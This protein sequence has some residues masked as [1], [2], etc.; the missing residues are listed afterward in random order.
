MSK[1]GLFIPPAYDRNVP[2]LGTPALVGFLKARGIHAEQHDLNLR[3]FAHL[4]RKRINRLFSEEYR[5]KKI[6]EKVYYR[7]I[8]QYEKLRKPF[9]YEFENNPGS[10]FAFAEKILSS[11]ILFRYLAD[12]EENLFVPFFAA[13]V[14]PLVQESRYDMVGFSLTAPSQ[15][16]AGFTFGYLLKKAAP[17]IKIVIG[18]QWVSFYREAL[19]KRK[20]FLELFDFMITF[21]GETPLYKLI[22]AVEKAGPL[23]E[24][25]NLIF[26]GRGRWKKSKNVCDEEMNNL[27]PPD[28]KGLPLRKYWQSKEGIT[29][30]M[31]TSRG[32]YWNRCIFC[33]DLPLPKPRYR[34]KS[35]ALVI[36]D[37]KTL[38]RQYG[39]KHLLIS[40]ATFSPWQMKEVAERILAEGI[41]V[42]WWTMAR[43][44]DGFDRETLMLAQQAGCTMIGFGLESINQRVLD[45]IDKGTRV[46]VIKRIIRDAHELQLGI[47]F[48]T[49]VGLPSETVEEAL[50]TIGFLAGSSYAVNRV[51]AFNIYYLIPKNRVF[52]NPERYGIRISPHQRLPFRYFYPFQHLTG[53]VDKPMARKLI[54]IHASKIHEKT[55]PSGGS[56]RHAESGEASHE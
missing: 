24:V 4:G 50:D 19:Q 32:C 3:Y 16:I 22:D 25:P 2:P 47:Y 44:D 54:H 5:E 55:S 53:T 11:R 38:V 37:M 8:L 52:L 36:R 49:M 27:P 43:L 31:E 15:V 10:S 18:G 35:P 12:E 33:I 26:G 51:S 21:E 40:N 30:T 20:V 29:L 56:D 39:A 1:I 46:D 13:E 23:S 41:K 9:S 6:K 7:A 45:F 42:T 14:L 34:E 17:Q 28:F 48:Q